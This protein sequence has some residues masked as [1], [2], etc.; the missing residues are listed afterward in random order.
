MLAQTSTPP[1]PAP[2]LLQTIKNIHNSLSQ[3]IKLIYVYDGIPPPHKKRTRESRRM[4]RDK[5]GEAWIQLIE[6]IKEDPCRNIDA[7]TLNEATKA[8]MGMH[9]PNAVDHANVLKW[10]KDNNIACIGSIAEADQQMIQLEKDG[11]VDGII[12]ED[13]DEIALGA[14]R[15]LCKM[16][17]KNN[18][19]YQFK[20]FDREYFLRD[21][22][23]YNSKLCQY[24]ELIT[25]AALL[26][27][28]DYCPRILNNGATTVVLGSKVP[29][30]GEL[31]EDEKK[32]YDQNPVRRDDS[33]LDALAAATDKESWLNN[34][35]TNGK[36][37]MQAEM[38]EIYRNAKRYMMYAP[39][40]K[41]DSTTG[42]VTIVP[43]N[44][45]P[46]NNPDDWGNFI[47]LRDLAALES[48][49]ELLLRIYNCD[50]VPLERKPLDAYTSYLSPRPLFGE[51]DY[52]AVPVK[53]QPT[54]CIINWLRARGVDM[55][56][57]EDRLCIESEVENCIRV[58]K[59][60]RLPALQPIVGVYD[61]YKSIR[62]RK[63][64]N[65]YDN[66]NRDYFSVASNQEFITDFAI[67]RY[68]GESRKSRP[69]IRQRVKN[70]FEGGHYDPKSIECRNVESK[71]DGSPC[72]LIRGKCLS[73]KSSVMHT[74][75][76]VFEDEPNGKY[77]VDLSSCSCK[78]GEHFC[79]HLIGFLYI[80]HVIQKGLQIDDPHTQDDFERFYRVNPLCVQ[81]CLMLIENVIV[82]DT[83]RQQQSQQNRMKRKLFIA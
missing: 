60:Q 66:W 43:L 67:D 32:K 7:A 27:G 30:P 35:G 77:S 69:S 56:A 28:N 29:A 40:L 38:A 63:A 44:K 54:L 21:D 12:S 39:V 37:P 49:S 42:K 20:L 36:R 53:I 68:L 78:K 14:R 13:G 52:D 6:Q 47:G 9:H 75:Y 83:F 10:M 34:F 64:Q 81:S 25:D 55:R 4:T 31:T 11:I 19:Q 17:R 22:N 65:Q 76:A 70:L 2:D 62:T 5:A 33:M 80:I 45:L 79:S 15:V 61:A 1:Y 71:V 73:S 24:P 57:N 16:S 72:M 58:Q 46:D 50:V 82:P 74:V 3:H 26:L 51:L 8:R 23:P 18:L 48:D 41:H 59:P